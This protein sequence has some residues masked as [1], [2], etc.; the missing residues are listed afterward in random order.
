[1]HNWHLLYYVIIEIGVCAPLNVHWI[2]IVQFEYAQDVFQLLHPRRIE[3]F[4]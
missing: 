1:M 4:H 2:P 3:L